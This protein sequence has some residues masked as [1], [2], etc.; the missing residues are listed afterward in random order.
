MAS[1]DRTGGVDTVEAAIIRLANDTR[2]CIA[3][4][5]ENIVFANA[6]Y[7]ISSVAHAG[8]N[9]G[10][11]VAILGVVT[12]QSDVAVFDGQVFDTASLNRITIQITE[13][14][15]VISTITVDVQSRDVMVIAV[16]MPDGLCGWGPCMRGGCS[17][18]TCFRKIAA[19]IE[20]AVIENDVIRELD[21]IAP[22]GGECCQPRK[23]LACGNEIRVA[24]TSAAGRRFRASVPHIRSCRQ[25]H[26]GQQAQAQAERQQDAYNSF[27]HGFSPPFGL[28]SGCISSQIIP[29]FLSALLSGIS[30]KTHPQTVRNARR[31]GSE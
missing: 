25:R 17:G 19:L 4:G 30:D 2:C 31:L 15:D 7:E 13:Q 12:S 8:K 10:F 11:A 16:N 9:A 27:F 18:F 24:L 14:P 28:L 21:I 6:V 23:L 29:M 26:R 3:G 22:F 20:C 5:R 1:I